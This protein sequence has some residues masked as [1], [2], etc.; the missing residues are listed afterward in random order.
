MNNKLTIV[1][2]LATGEELVYSLPPY[3]AVVAAFEQQTND[4]KATWTYCNPCDHPAFR[5]GN[6]SVACGDWTAIK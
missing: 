4:N 6:V 1:I 3:E 5:E 2:N